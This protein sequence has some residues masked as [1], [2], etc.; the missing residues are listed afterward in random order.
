MAKKLTPAEKTKRAKARAEAR[1]QKFRAKTWEE[2][3]GPALYGAISQTHLLLNV[4]AWRES[5][6]KHVQK[7]RP[8]IA[9]IVRAFTSRK[10]RRA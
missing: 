5:A 7:V 2:R 9:A 3:H 10:P 4:K 1:G 8:L 6:P